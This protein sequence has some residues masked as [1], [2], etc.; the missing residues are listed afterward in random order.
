MLFHSRSSMVLVIRKNFLLLVQSLIADSMSI[1]SLL[2][3]AGW[4]ESLCSY[5][6]RGLE[7]ISAAIYS[8]IYGKDQMTITGNLQTALADIVE[9]HRDTTIAFAGFWDS[10][11]GC[12]I[13]L[14]N[15]IEYVITP[16][17]ANLLIQEDLQTSED[18][19]N[20]HR[21]RS[22]NVGDSFQYTDGSDEVSI[23][24]LYSTVFY[25]CSTEHCR[26]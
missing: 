14:T 17:V 7:I 24:N 6:P 2:V 12:L 3:L 19:A 20:T 8:T 21:L 23:K 13:S 15:F 25:F 26:I 10:A 5:G 4:A 16:H 18:N 11:D 1:I 9:N 22:K